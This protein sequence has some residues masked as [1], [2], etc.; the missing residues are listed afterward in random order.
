MY[1]IAIIGGGIGGMYCCK[2]LSKKYKV[3]LFDERN[4]LGGRVKTHY[5]PQLEEGAGR[6]HSSHKILLQIIKKCDLTKIK[7]GG[8]KDYISLNGKIIPN[9]NDYFDKKMIQILKYASSLSKKELQKYT[10]KEFLEK[11]ISKKDIQELINIFGYTSE[12]YV[13]NAYDSLQA[14][15]NTFIGG[16]FFVLKEGLRQ[17]ITC[18][19]QCSRENGAIIKKKSKIINIE[20]LENCFSLYTDN[21]IYYS[22]KIIFGTKA[23]NLLE[24]SILKPIFKEIKSVTFT[25]LLRIY[26]KYPKQNGEVWFNNMNTISTNSILRQIIPLNYE[27]GLIMISYTDGTDVKPFLTK[28]GKLR[29]ESALKNIIKS[30]LKKLFPNKKI[31][32]P[33]FFHPYLWK[34]GCHYWKKNNN[35][36]KISKFMINPLKNIYICG[37]SFST[38]QAWMEGALET[39]TEVIKKIKN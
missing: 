22:Q 30:E 8:P 11:I 14:F 39:A 38:N 32:E 31:P 24:F 16:N 4:Y 33:T 9:A 28:Y 6:F 19:E 23:H 13:M 35:S 7:I 17:I 21:N 12:F 5:N 3:I 10:L 29:S 15:K 34:Q 37:E 27:T 36:T 26:A 1:D 18:L 25:P 2:Q 20:K